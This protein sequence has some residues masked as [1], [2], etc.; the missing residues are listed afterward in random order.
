MTTLFNSLFRC[1]KNNE[2]DMSDEIT[3]TS[4]ESQWHHSS[5][6]S[7]SNW[8]ITLFTKSKM[9]LIIFKNHVAFTIHQKSFASFLTQDVSAVPIDATVGMTLISGIFLFF[10]MSYEKN[11]DDIS[12]SSSNKE[13]PE[14]DT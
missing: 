3:F 4:T 5:M 13:N 10:G 12:I 8:K 7:K 14:N 1:L 11:E 6:T 2:T 9:S